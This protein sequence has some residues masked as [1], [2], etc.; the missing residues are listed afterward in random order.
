MRPCCRQ[1]T[2]RPSAHEYVLRQPRHRPGRL[3]GGV[4]GWAGTSCSAATLPSAGACPS[5]AGSIGFPSGWA[6]QHVGY[7][8]PSSRLTSPKYAGLLEYGGDISGAYLL[9]RALFMPWELPGVMGEEAAVEGLGE[10]DVLSTLEAVTVGIIAP[11]DRVI[12]LELSVYLR[13]CLLRDADWAGMAHSLEIR[14]PLV[15]VELFAQLAALR[16]QKG[17]AP[18][19]KRDLAS[20]PTQPLPAKITPGRKPDSMCRWGNGSCTTSTMVASGALLSGAAVVGR[21]QWQ[22]ASERESHRAGTALTLSREILP[23][24]SL[25]AVLAFDT[26]GRGDHAG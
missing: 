5:Y 24:T 18:W 9:R 3:E 25:R 10:L 14:T 21:G 19:G 11:Y 15:D 6:G 13:N 4:S 16:R 1:W 17:G 22:P 2:S 23:S 26:Q 20:A 7:W 8:S 12:A